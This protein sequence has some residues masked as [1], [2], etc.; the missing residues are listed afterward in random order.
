MEPP[1]L[2]LQRSLVVK[3]TGRKNAALGNARFGDEGVNFMKLRLKNNTL[4]FRTTRSEVSRLIEL[5]HLEETIQFGA[6][7]AAAFTF[8]IVL[9]SDAICMAV[10]Y[11]PSTI[12]LLVSAAEA[13]TWAHSNAVG[14]YATVEGGP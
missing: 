11:A 9:G 12:T 1:K 5:G 10:R 14:I 3:S 7:D 4:R 2:S 13:R 6:E 8:A